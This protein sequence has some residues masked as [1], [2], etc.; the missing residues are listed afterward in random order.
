MTEDQ[1]QQSQTLRTTARQAKAQ[2]K[3][4]HTCEAV[5]PERI[6]QHL[7]PRN[8]ELGVITVIACHGNL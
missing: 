8:F 5:A 1:R 3:G 2:G 4:V 7:R 6:E